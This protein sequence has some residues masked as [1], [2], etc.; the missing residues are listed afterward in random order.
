[1]EQIAF[2]GKSNTKLISRKVYIKKGNIYM[3]YLY[4]IMGKFVYVSLDQLI[5]NRFFQQ[6]NSI[7]NSVI[8]TTNS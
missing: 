3:K 1:M 7:L 6:I 2:F 8:L 5:I 4:E